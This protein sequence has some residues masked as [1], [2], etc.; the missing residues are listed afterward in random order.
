MAG[1]TL[2]KA[3][4]EVTTIA[5]GFIPILSPKA[6]NPA[7][8]SSVTGK[9]LNESSSNKLFAMMAFLLPGHNTTFSTLYSLSSPISMFTLSSL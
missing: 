7:E 5:E 6:K 4:P 9:Q 3:E 1:A 2:S 8:R